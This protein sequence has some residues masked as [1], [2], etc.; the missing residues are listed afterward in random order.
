MMQTSASGNAARKRGMTKLPKIGFI[1]CKHAD[2]DAECRA[3]V[4]E[5]ETVMQS[6][7]VVNH[8]QAGLYA[9]IDRRRQ[10]P[11]LWPWW[12]GAPHALPVK[13][14]ATFKLN[15]VHHE[16]SFSSG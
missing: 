14:V 15:P 16:I 13:G 2:Q 11:P 10:G 4:V 12:L 6:G 5:G 8:G 9:A 7:I 1:A 3:P